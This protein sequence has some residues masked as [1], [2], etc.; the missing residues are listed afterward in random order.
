MDSQFSPD[1]LEILK[2]VAIVFAAGFIGYFGRHLAKQLI[3]RVRQKVTKAPE[4]PTIPPAKTEIIK[5]TVIK[6]TEKSEAD[7]LKLEKKRLK[8]EKKKAK[9]AEK[10]EPPDQN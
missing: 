7:K 3:D 10:S 1:P 5:E 2:W 4:A 9:K 6:E 8:L